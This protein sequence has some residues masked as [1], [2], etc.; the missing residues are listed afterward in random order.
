MY[1]LRS[2][3]II[4]AAKGKP[5][6]TSGH[7]QVCENEAKVKPQPAPK[8]GGLGKTR[9]CVVEGV[10][11]VLVIQGSTLSLPVLATPYPY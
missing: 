7:T 10:C 1:L 11:V 3:C 8:K 5:P 9:R 2:I 4:T 6:N